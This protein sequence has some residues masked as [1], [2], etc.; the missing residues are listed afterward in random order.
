MRILVVDNGGQW[1]HREWRVLRDLGVE[2]SIVPNSTP[3]ESISADGLVLSGGAPR[4]GLDE[5]AMGMCGAY[6][7][8][9]EVP[10]LG[11]CAGHQ[12]MAL[13]LGGKAVPSATPEFGKTLVSVVD[14]DDLF[15]GL[16]ETFV[17]WESHNDEVTELP[18]G[19]KLLANSETCPVQAMKHETR[20][21]YGL[22]FHPEVEHTD[23]GYE[24]FQAFLDVC[25]AR[26]KG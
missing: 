25:E 24:I 8:K 10:I 2:T 14:E 5:E 11:I 23:N 16:P 22:Q 20:P 15:K 6:I 13:R 3:L 18:P 7:D 19:F 21:L 9:L 26:K 12:Y 4:V 17:A 1:T